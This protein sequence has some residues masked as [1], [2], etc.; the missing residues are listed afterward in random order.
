MFLKDWCCVLVVKFGVLHFGSPGSVPGHGPTPLVGG[1]AV[2][3]THIQN[4]TAGTDV[5][6]RQIFLSKKKKIFLIQHLVV[7]KQDDSPTV[8]SPP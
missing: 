2:V 7:L 1:H 8:S 3:V 5:S 4:R 6:S